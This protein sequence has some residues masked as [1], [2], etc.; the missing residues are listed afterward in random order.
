MC[1]IIGIVTVCVTIVTSLFACGSEPPVVVEKTVEVEVPVEVIKEVVREVPVEMVVEKEVVKEVPVEVVVEKVVVKEVPVEVVVEKEVIKEVP[2]EVV[3]EREVIKEVPVEVVVE[4]IVEVEVP[5]PTPTPRSDEDTGT[6]ETDR[7]AL[8]A[9]Y[10]AT[11]GP[12]WYESQN[13]LSDRPP[14]DWYG[15]R[16]SKDGRVTRLDL[17]NNN[18]NGEIPSETRQPLQPDQLASR[19]QPAGWRDT[20]RTGQPLQ[21]DRT[22]AI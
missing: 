7:A 14:G 8:V 18:V 13:W 9:L 21:P 19:Q 10:N 4:K 12:D 20:A 15:V 17:V 16:T 11:D 1:R 22:R 3:V 2:V 5:L 6:S